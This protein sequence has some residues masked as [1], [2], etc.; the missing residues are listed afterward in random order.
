MADLSALYVFE[1]SWL[2]MLK[3]LPDLM[4]DRCHCLMQCKPKI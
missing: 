4:N 3:I 2:S 1:K